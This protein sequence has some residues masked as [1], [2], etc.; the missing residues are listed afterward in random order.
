MY[1]YA[2]NDRDNISL[3]EEYTL[4]QLANEYLKKTDSHLD[5]LIKYGELFEVT[6]DKTT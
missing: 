4:K 6:H 5:L 2:K 3:K 1:G